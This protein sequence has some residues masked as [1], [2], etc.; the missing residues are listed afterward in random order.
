M[1][2]STVTQLVADDP[3]DGANGEVQYTQSP[4][5]PTI[6]FEIDMNSGTIRT[7]L[8]FDYDKGGRQ[9]SM[10]VMTTYCVSIPRSHTLSH[11]SGYC[12]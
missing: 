3:D 7:T 9:F 6:P 11:H 10:E 8:S 5:S 1:V 12:H 4:Q 2:G